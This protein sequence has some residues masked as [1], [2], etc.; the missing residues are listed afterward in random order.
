[1][2]GE[3]RGIGELEARRAG[4]KELGA[5]WAGKEELDGVCVPPGFTFTLFRNR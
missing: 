5:A 2:S 4:E 1:M 3:E